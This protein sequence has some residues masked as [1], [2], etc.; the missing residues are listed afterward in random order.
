MALF[1]TPDGQDVEEGDY[2]VVEDE[3][4]EPVEAIEFFVDEEED[5]VRFE[6]A[7][8]K[9]RYPV[10]HFQREEPEWMTETLAEHHPPE[11]YDY[12]VRS[13]LTEKLRTK[14]GL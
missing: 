1:E 8:K 13:S 10:G 4:G 3:H 2:L 12:E 6:P 14:L 5:V 7:R 11:E 9:D